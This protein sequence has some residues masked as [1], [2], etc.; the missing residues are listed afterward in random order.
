M[1]RRKFQ[2][3][4]EKIRNN[5]NQYSPY[6]FKQDQTAHEKNDKE[7]YQIKGTHFLRKLTNFEV[8]VSFSQESLIGQEITPQLEVDG[9][10]LTG[11]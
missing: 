8:C 2:E 5:K 1:D 4:M 6:G 7:K 11:E 3:G 10:V 9:M